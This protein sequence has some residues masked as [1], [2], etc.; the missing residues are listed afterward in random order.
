MTVPTAPAAGSNAT[1][2]VG[3]R[4]RDAAGGGRGLRRHEPG[5]APR[6]GLDEARR[7]RRISQRLPHSVDERVDAGVDVDEGV[8]S[9]EGG[10]DLFAR[11]QL[12]RPSHQQFEPLAGL[13]LQPDSAPVARQISR[14][15]IRT[16]R[17]FAHKIISTN[18]R[19]TSLIVFWPVGD[20]GEPIPSN[21][22][23]APTS[24][25]AWATADRPGT[26]PWGSASG[27]PGL[28]ERAA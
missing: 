24:G 17:F 13:F 12:A 19:R 6:K 23:S 25:L 20:P 2:A 3:N 4:S 18:T 21:P 14:D 28:P 8:V 22:V 7:R 26:R 15:G 16:P 5:A 10:P 9:P 1:G 27:P 11:D